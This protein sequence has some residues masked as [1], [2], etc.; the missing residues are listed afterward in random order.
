MNHVALV[1]ML[2][3]LIPVITLTVYFVIRIMKNEK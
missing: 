3:T 2:A 1:L